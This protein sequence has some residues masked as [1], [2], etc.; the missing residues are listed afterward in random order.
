MVPLGEVIEQVEAWSPRSKPDCEFTYID[1]S[2]VDNQVKAITGGSRL[3]GQDA[4]SR[5][6]QLIQTRDVLVSTVRPNLNAV[7][8]V[9]ARFDGATAS[10]GFTVLRPS[11]RIDDR[12]MYHW[13]RTREFVADM[14]G[15][16]TGASYPAVSDR[17]VKQ[18]EIPLPQ[19]DEQRRI[20]TILDHADALRRKRL[21][22]HAEL[23]AL[24]KSVFRD[25]FGDFSEQN[26][27][28]PIVVFGDLIINGPQNGL[29]KPAKDYGD[30]TPIVRIDSFQNG[31]PIDIAAL[32]RVR[33]TINDAKR[34]SLSD[35][36]IVINR[37]NARSH[38]G[39]ATMVKGFTETTLFESNMMRFSID[40][41]LA[42]PQYIVAALGTPYLN[43]QI[44]AAAKDAVNQSSINQKDVMGF[45][46]PLPA[47]DQQAQY[48]RQA[49]SVQ[50]LQANGTKNTAALDRLF[51]ALQSRAFRGEL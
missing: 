6:R 36:D 40:T 10:T 14:V 21:R 22:T 38:L 48:I 35:G 15:K 42:F 8:A 1:L 43:D 50:K 39:K 16:A 5:A 44:Q 33:V 23:D 47:L 11:N 34:Y 31:R 19:F 46:I 32:K 27:R 17:I 26:L 29:Y 41:R 12:Y 18:S 28:W 49:Q 7:A 24:V 37:V 13:V 4:P 30:G 25:T 3:L 2:S 51:A 9:D 20:A 45:R